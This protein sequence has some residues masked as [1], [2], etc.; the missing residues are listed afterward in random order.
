[1]LD[2]RLA[3]EQLVER[4]IPLLQLMRLDAHPRRQAGLAFGVV[5]PCRDETAATAI[6]DKIVLQP[7]RQCMLASWR[8]QSIGD[9]HQRPIAQPHRLAAIS[10]RQ[11][12]EHRLE[13]KLAPHCTRGQHRPP[14]P[15]PARS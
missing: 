15:R 6:A 11:L 14:V 12:I 8:R 7:L 5:T 3:G 9:Q 13:A 4:T 1:M 2:L 10:P